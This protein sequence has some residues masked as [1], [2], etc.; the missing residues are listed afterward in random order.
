MSEDKNEQGNKLQRYDKFGEPVYRHCCDIDR[1][2]LSSS[3]FWKA[4]GGRTSFSDLQEEFFRKVSCKYGA[5]RGESK[6]LI[7]NTNAE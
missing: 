7:K 4:R 6:S 5:V 3:A 2:R 1:P